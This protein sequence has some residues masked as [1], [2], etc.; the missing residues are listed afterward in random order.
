MNTS[1]IKSYAIQARRDFLKAVTER[2]N[3]YGIASDSNIEGIQFK[4]DLA[5]IGDRAIPKKEGELREKLAGRIRR[6]GFEQVMRASAYTWFNRLV[7]IRYMELHDY[8][9]HGY[10]VLSGKNESDMPE[11][12]AHA[13][14]LDLPGLNKNQVVELKLAGNKDNEIYRLLLIAQCHALYKAMPFLFNRI[15]SET[16]LLLPENLLHS[17]SPI[18]KMVKD[19]DEED[20]Q[21]VEIIGWIYQ[22]YISEK[23]DEVIGKVVKNEDIPAATQL[24]TPN[25]IVKY[26]VQNTLGRMWLATYPD[27]PL[28]QKMEYYIEPAKQ[29]AEVQKKIDSI[30]P[31][32]LNPEELTFL[33]PACGSGHILVEAYNIFKEIYLERGYRSKD[34]PRLIL[35]KN[36]F[37]L[38]IDDRAAQLAGFAVLMRARRDDRRILAQDHPELNVMA[39]QETKSFDAEKITSTL[40]REKIIRYSEKD[41]LFPDFIGQMPLRV[42]ERPGVTHDDLFEIIELFK[43][44]KTFGSLIKI[45]GEIVAKISLIKR[46]INEKLHNGDMFE[47]DSTDKLSP[48]LLQAAI[49]AKKYDCIVTNPPYM[50]GKGR[51]SSLLKDFAMIHFQD[52]KQDLFAMFAERIMFM[53]KKFGLISLV[54]PYVWM[55]LSSY[56]SF[57]V[58]MLQKTNLNSLIQLEYNAFEPACVPVA[59]FSLGVQPIPNY[60]GDFI[61]LSAFKGYQNQ[62]PRTIEAIQNSSCKWRYKASSA[63]F[64]KIP[65]APIAYWA[66]NKIKEIFEKSIVIGDVSEPR[67][68]LATSDNDRFLRFWP[69]VSIKKVGFGMRSSQEA[70]DS[71]KKWFPYNKGGKFRKWYGNNEFVINFI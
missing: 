6:D 56:E 4:G 52:S 59:S 8:L 70:K 50:S 20:W 69:E 17:D 66:S 45:P 36:L 16:E 18:R 35:K 64:K 40:I 25:W 12:M 46:F 29:D 68:G 5:I 27:S 33:D 2:A 41:Q 55:F 43:D 65:G 11:I 49:L 19:I 39:I 14:N 54:M 67:Q 15:D 57:R 32:E 23:K 28:R 34:I 60:K 26:M 31:K 62:A 21:D 58:K 44:G 3:F 37:G 10:R 1:K 51:M 48:I 42:T 47:R 30:R 63:D 7:A 22:F 38:D 9:D 61:K 13:Q 53:T 24:F 71:M